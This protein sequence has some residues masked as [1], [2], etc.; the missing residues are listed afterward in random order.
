MALKNEN[1]N[2]LR[3]TNFNVFLKR[4]GNSH[5]NLNLDLWE[6]EEKRLDPTDFDKAISFNKRVNVDLL[7]DEINL[8]NLS[9]E[10]L[11][12]TKAYDYLKNTDYVDWIDC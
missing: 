12:L 11:L 4:D 8:N 10:D 7:K 9:F 5:I 2:Y 3:I 6:S 1:G